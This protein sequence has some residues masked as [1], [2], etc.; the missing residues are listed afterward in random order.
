L[1]GAVP[2]GLREGRRA[3]LQFSAVDGIRE[4]SPSIIDQQK[5]M[6]IQVLPEQGQTESPQSRGPPP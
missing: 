5:I 1:S 2:F 6:Y 3:V 4:T